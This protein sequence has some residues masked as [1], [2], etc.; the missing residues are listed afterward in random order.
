[1]FTSLSLFL[2]STPLT[3]STPEVSVFASVTAALVASGSIA[4]RP[5]AASPVTA[6]PIAKTPRAIQK[7]AVRPPVTKLSAAAREAFVK[8]KVKPVAAT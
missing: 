2:N 7:I 4:V 8:A 5:D 1:M 3:G 6:S